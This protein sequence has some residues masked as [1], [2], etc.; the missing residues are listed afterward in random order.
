M[1]TARHRCMNDSP[2]ILCEELISIG[3]LRLN[4]AIG[5]PHGP[6]LVLL[7]GVTRR[8]TDYSPLT[9]TLVA[10]Y[11]LHAL[12]FRGHGLSGRGNSY[13]VVD[14]L[15]DAES[16]IP[17]LSRSLGEPVV[18]YG[19]SLGAMVAAGVAATA[20]EAVRAVILEDPP[21]ETM[22]LRIRQT[23]YYR[24]FMGMRELA[25]RGGSADELARGLA[26]VRVP[27]ACGEK[28]L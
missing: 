11:H 18:V 28:R 6:P 26:D 2:S 12:D 8:W 21:Y 5:P 4:V 7:H 27:T 22:G 9:S 23:P 20:P 24:Q 10:H 15:R 17:S 19:H 14:Y 16:W 1:E 3:D 25:R 13:L